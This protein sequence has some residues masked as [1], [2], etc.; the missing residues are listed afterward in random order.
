MGKK[1]DDKKSFASQLL[2]G[3]ITE[4]GEIG[5]RKKKVEK[6]NPVIEDINRII[7]DDNFQELIKPGID[8]IAEKFDNPDD[9]AAFKAATQAKAKPFA[10]GEHK[11]DKRYVE[12]PDNGKIT[13]RYKDN[14]K[15]TYTRDSVGKAIN[16]NWVTYKH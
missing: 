11:D 12:Y 2:D 6:K 10:L 5:M 1:K 14:C 16:L 15:L 3:I 8:K 9:K 4:D 13:R 7:H